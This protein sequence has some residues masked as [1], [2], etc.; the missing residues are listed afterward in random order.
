MASCQHRCGAAL[1]KGRARAL[2]ITCSHRGGLAT[3]STTAAGLSIRHGALRPGISALEVRLVVGGREGIAAALSSTVR[4]PRWLHLVSRS[5]SP[6]SCI[7]HS[8]VQTARQCRRSERLI[9]WSRVEIG[10]S[11]CGSACDARAVVRGRSRRQSCV[12]VRV[13][14]FGPQRDSEEAISPPRTPADVSRIRIARRTYGKRPGWSRNDHGKSSSDKMKFHLICARLRQ[15]TQRRYY[16]PHASGRRSRALRRVGAIPGSVDISWAYSRD[17]AR[18]VTI[19]FA[20]PS[21]PDL[22][23][24]RTHP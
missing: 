24:S 3:R 5:L 17:L 20:P 16:H 22:G 21:T 12:V 19:Y 8:I 11:L 6:C 23:I 13:Q 14:S 18:P 1:P 15:R 10:C 2:S 9:D 7:R 4:A